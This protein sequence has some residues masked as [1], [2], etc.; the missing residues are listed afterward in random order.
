MPDRKWHNF[1]IV[2]K[3]VLR[4][5]LAI[6]LL[7]LGILFVLVVPN[8]IGFGMLS[9]SMAAVA[10]YALLKLQDESF[11]RDALEEA[12]EQRRRGSSLDRTFRIEEL[13]VESRVRMKTII[14]LQAEIADDVAE[15]PVDEVACGLSDTVTRTEELV[16]RALAMAQQRRELLRYLNRTDRDAIV[17]RVQG[18]EASLQTEQDAVRQAELSASLAS[19]RKE[20]EDYEAIQRA[21]ARVLD[22]LDAIECAFS[23]LRARIVR[24]KSTNIAE[25]VAA[26]TELQ[27]E[28]GGL[29]SAVETLE[30]SINEVL[31]LGNTG[32]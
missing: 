5:P 13:D 11:I 14:R 22:Q 25:W 12:R 20:L 6:S 31:T 24:I 18:F 10:A 1:K 17:S 3:R 2:I 32:Q 4:T 9:A 28:L 16:D 30:Q 8:S 21:S 26:N 7:G 23:E 29:N 15:S 27:T 19:K